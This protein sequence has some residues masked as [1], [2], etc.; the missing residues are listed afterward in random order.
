MVVTNEINDEIYEA[1]INYA[2]Q[3][4]DAVMFVVRRDI[5]INDIRIDKI[6]LNEL[7]Q[8]MKKYTNIC[9]NYLLKLKHSS[10]RIYSRSL[11]DDEMFDVYFYKFSNTVKELLL[12]N[13]SFYSWLHP[14]YPEDIAFFKNGYCWLWSIAHEEI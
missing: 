14:N 2:F 4:C 12:E 9:K 10:K 3:K 8:N 5:Y 11:A 7:K 1:L 13:R 6:G